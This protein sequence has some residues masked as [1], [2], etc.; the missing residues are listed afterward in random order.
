VN[1]K[2]KR[3]AARRRHEQKASKRGAAVFASV[4]RLN[5][6]L[7]HGDVMGAF[8]VVAEAPESQRAMLAEAADALQVHEKRLGEFK[9]G[10]MVIKVD[11][12]KH[13]NLSK[14]IGELIRYEFGRQSHIAWTVPG[15]PF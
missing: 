7:Q 5:D 3:L 6:Q 9:N 14:R 1:K 12:A 13:P 4:R 10:H 2:S 11:P 8:R 15:K